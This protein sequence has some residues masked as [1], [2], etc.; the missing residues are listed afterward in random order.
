[1]P[2]PPKYGTEGKDGEGGYTKSEAIAAAEALGHR[3]SRWW[4]G[5]LTYD[6]AKCVQ[7]G[8]RVW[9]YVK[10]KLVCNSPGLEKPCKVEME[11][12]HEPRLAL[13]LR[14]FEL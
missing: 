11:R 3:M 2:Y 1:M 13:L 7:C 12:L 8:A 4:P 9:Y 10:A 5:R 6:M 14:R